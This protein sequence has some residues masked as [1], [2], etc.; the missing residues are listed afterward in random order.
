MKRFPF[1]ACLAFLFLLIPAGVTAAGSAANTT[2]TN[3]TTVATTTAP[4]RVGGSIYFDTD[5]TGATIW[6]D[7][8][9]I[10]TSTFTYY[11]ENTGTFDVRVWKKG[12]ENYTGTVTVSEGKRV[13]FEAWLTPVSREIMGENTPAAPVA[14]ATTIRRSTIDIPTPWPTSAPE[15]PVDPAA[16]IGAAA[17]GIGFFVIRRR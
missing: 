12:Y 1:L 8:V 9:S 14:T 3:V 7:N 15:S 11:T 16:V 6:L 13:V 10:G 2:T 4:D 17:L 5:P